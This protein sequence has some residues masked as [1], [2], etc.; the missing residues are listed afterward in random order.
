M[1]P[2][3][4]F[5]SKGVGIP[6]LRVQTFLK[7]NKIF[8]YSP[9]KDGTVYVQVNDQ[10]VKILKKDNIIKTL[11]DFIKNY[12]FK[13]QNQKELVHD[14]LSNKNSWIRINLN[15]WLEEAALSF[16]KDSPTESYVFFRNCVVKI[17]SKKITTCHYSEIEGHVWE[18]H[19]IDR[20]FTLNQPACYAELTGPFHNFLHLITTNGTDNFE[21]LLTII[22]YVLH[23]YKDPSRSK[24][25]IFYDINVNQERQN[26]RSCKTLL[27]R[28]LNEVRN[29][30]LENGKLIDPTTKFA[31]NRVSLDTNGI[32]FDDI[33]KHLK[34][35]KFFSIITGDLT[36]E[37]KFENSV[38]IPFADSPKIIF[39]SNYIVQ[40]EGLSHS[41]RRVEFFISDYFNPENT[42]LSYFGKRFFEEWTDEEYNQF[43]NTMVMAIEYYLE[44]G[45]Q[46]PTLS[47]YY[48]IL[49]NSSPNNF[50]DKCDAYILPNEKYSKTDL[51][52]E[53]K[54]DIP[55]LDATTQ[56]TFTGL[57]KKYADYQGWSV[58]ESH[59]GDKYYITF[60]SNDKAED[61]V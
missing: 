8:K 6:S 49:R 36:K 5:N 40:G 1:T 15:N 3:F 46:E 55:D 24:C 56:Y 22:G 50:I 17:T 45:I 41:D 30:L 48:Y 10:K 53:F 9:S 60:I 20:D 12:E 21:S 42:P 38:T 27:C 34:F 31:F 7:E 39:T 51:F 35:E 14:K 58:T 47:R 37:E 25:V 2:Y 28:A 61:G 16:I 19:I 59:S 26:G 18:E 54:K 29:I 44:H 11:F 33:P 43:Y 52:E 13:D 57:L 32:V 23:R 4:E